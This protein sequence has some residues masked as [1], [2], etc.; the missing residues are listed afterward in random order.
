M[1]TC[2]IP[3]LPSQVTEEALPAPPPPSVILT[4]SYLPPQFKLFL[5]PKPHLS[6]VRIRINCIFQQEVTINHTGSKPKRKQN[7]YSASSH[8]GKWRNRVNFKFGWSAHSIVHLK[9]QVLSILFLCHPQLHLK[10]DHRVTATCNCCDMLVSS[11]RDEDPDDV[12]SLINKGA[13]V[14]ICL[15]HNLQPTFHWPRK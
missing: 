15:N 4:T 8:N 3:P 11:S 1:Q 2:L 10:D 13:P 12:N 7:L 14:G 5:K 6:V 9:P